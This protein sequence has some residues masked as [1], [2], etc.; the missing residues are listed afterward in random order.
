MVDRK[1]RSLFGGSRLRNTSL[2][3]DD[4]PPVGALVHGA[5]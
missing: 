1:V 2:Y 3:G 4:G 5:E